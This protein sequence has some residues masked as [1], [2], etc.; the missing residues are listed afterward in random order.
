[1]NKFII[2]EDFPKS[3]IEFDQKSSYESACYQYLFTMKWP[4]GFIC[5]KCNYHYCW[6]SKRNIYICQRCQHNNGQ[7]KKTSHLLV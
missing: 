5:V 1:M 2:M 3:E 6:L 7:L 4:Q